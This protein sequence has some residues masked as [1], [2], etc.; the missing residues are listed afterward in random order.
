MRTASL[1]AATLLVATLLAGQVAAQVPYTATSTYIDEVNSAALANYPYVNHWTGSGFANSVPVAFGYTAAVLHP[2]YNSVSFHG[3]MPPAEPIY[4]AGGYLGFYA[5][6]GYGY[7]QP[8]WDYAPSYMYG[9]DPG[10][11]V[12]GYHYPL[13]GQYFAPSTM[14]HYPNWMAY[15][16]S[17]DVGGA[18][19]DV[20]DPAAG[21]DYDAGKYGLVDPASTATIP[22]SA[23][24]PAMYGN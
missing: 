4:A 5:Y 19:G 13:Y 1:L 6:P 16:W 24:F 23:Y 14:Y 2:V 17:H 10:D 21:L 11:Q 18:F 8:A 9:P 15:D 22:A 7:Y 20:T 3:V 12:S